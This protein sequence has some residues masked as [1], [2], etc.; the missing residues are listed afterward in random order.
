MSDISPRLELPLLQPAQAQKHVTHNE[1]LRIL[2]IFVQLT[3][4]EFEA[5][6][7]PV[8]PVEGPVYRLE[9]LVSGISADNRHDEV[10]TGI[11]VGHE[12]RL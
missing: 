8:S 1:A 2:D 11:G 3:V 9:D 5:T 10:D 6:D 12:S 7:P 4:E